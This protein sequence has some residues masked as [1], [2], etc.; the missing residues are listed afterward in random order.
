[1]HFKKCRRSSS[2][3]SSLCPTCS[4]IT[5]AGNR[6]PIRAVL[7]DVLRRQRARLR[8]T[9]SFEASAACA[10]KPGDESHLAYTDRPRARYI[11]DGHRPA[12]AHVGNKRKPWWVLSTAHA[13]A[14]V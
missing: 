11:P 7:R 5:G 10:E 12:S 4:S 3:S 14:A 1:M 13:V 8:T 9:T 2:F 6:R